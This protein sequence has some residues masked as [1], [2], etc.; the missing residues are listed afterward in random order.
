[1]VSAWTQRSVKLEASSLR[2]EMVKLQAD[3]AQRASSDKAELMKA[4]DGGHLRAAVVE[5]QIGQ[6]ERR[7]ATIETELKEL[8]ALL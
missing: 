1:M 7:V 4:I 3:L 2:L 8:R 6:L 5:A